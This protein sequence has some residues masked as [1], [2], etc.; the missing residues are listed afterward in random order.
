[1]KKYRMSASPLLEP[2]PE[3]RN[4]SNRN[5]QAVLE[6][7]DVQEEILFEVR[8]EE[9]SSTFQNLF[10]HQSDVSPLCSSE[11]K[12]APES[13]EDPAV[14]RCGAPYNES[15]RHLLSAAVVS[16]D[17]ASH[18]ILPS[19]S[20]CDFEL[21]PDLNHRSH[22][23]SEEQVVR[24]ISSTADWNSNESSPTDTRSKALV[25]LFLQ[26]ISA[27]SEPPPRVKVRSESDSDEELFAELKGTS[28]G[29]RCWGKGRASFKRLRISSDPE[30]VK[31]KRKYESRKKKNKEERFQGIASLDDTTRQLLEM[32]IVKP[33]SMFESTS[34]E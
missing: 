9:T 14:I 8:E 28:N 23:G 26:E 15:G 10:S 33:L 13:A 5:E 29:K 17:T 16:N 18:F 31:R 12:T 4:E 34:G 27:W 22:Q 24:N 20:D 21:A 3:M 25:N 30:H 2:S 19:I 7:S 6:R 1:M 11:D 32:D